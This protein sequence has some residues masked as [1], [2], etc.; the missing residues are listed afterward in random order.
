MRPHRPNHHVPQKPNES[1]EAYRLRRK[2]THVQQE[3]AKERR[4][5]KRVEAEERNRRD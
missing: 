4:Y 1:R 5:R 3:T 2:D